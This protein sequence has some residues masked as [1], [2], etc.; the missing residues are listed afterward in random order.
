LEEITMDRYYLRLAVAALLI[1]SASQPL[2]AANETGSQDVQTE[3]QQ[4]QQSL[5]LLRQDYEARIAALEARLAAAEQSAVAITQSQ[6]AQVAVQSAI[7]PES[8]ALPGSRVSSA[9]SRASATTSNAFNPAIGVIFQGQAW[10]FKEDPD[11]Y[12]IPAFP[13]GGEAGLLDQGLALGETEIDISANVDDLFTAWLTVPIM[14]EDGETDIEIEEAWLETTALPAGFSARFGR[15]FSAIGYLNS[16]HSHAWDFADQPLVYQAFLGE[17]YIDDGVQL[18]WL[19]PTD[20]YWELGG[21]VLRGGGYPAQGATNGGVGSQTLF[22]RWGGDVGSSNSWLAGLSYLH[23]ESDD[24][25]SGNADAPL[26]F[27][28]NTD[29]LIGQMLWKWSPQGNWKQ[30]NLSLQSEVMWRNEDGRY[31][32]ANDTSAVL[33]ND[34]YGFYLQAIYQPFPQWRIGARYDWLS[35]NDPGA[36]FANTGLAA[37][38]GSPQRYTVMLDWSHS[39]FSR[40]RFQYSRDQ[41]GLLN[42]NQ[43]G[44]QYI[45][46]IG[47]HGAHSF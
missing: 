26:T 39:E 45:L 29:L 12:R 1:A 33:D 13:L 5:R 30:R 4:L 16:I 15:M 10:H 2:T 22:S 3:L 41:A 43:W 25:Q 44:L 38:G 27:N 31:R 37:V 28:G 7:Q 17:Q 24:R 19:A 11:Q 9:E 46:S 23:A 14:V 21:E 18:R 8:L 34:Q 36:E 20:T 6:Q 35:S 42:D 40:L 47:A 32:F